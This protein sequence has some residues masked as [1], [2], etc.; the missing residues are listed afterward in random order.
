MSRRGAVRSSGAG[1]IAL[2]LLLSAC[3]TGHGTSSHD[4]N[5][6]SHYEPIADASSWPALKADL[7][8][9]VA[10]RV[11]SVRVVGHEDDKRVV[12]LLNR[13]ER[14]VMQVDAWRTS[15]GTWVA[16]RW[17]QCID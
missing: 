9:N 1:V 10:S 8:A 13:R 3:S 14:V 17:S 5:C 2:C 11:R 7:R 15:D 4:P 16:Q 12:S 6:T